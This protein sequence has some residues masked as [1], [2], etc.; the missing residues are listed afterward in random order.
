MKDLIN[1]EFKIV[2]IL[3]KGYKVD[4]LT[5]TLIEQFKD[6]NLLLLQDKNLYHS[7]KRLQ[8]CFGMDLIEQINYYADEFDVLIIDKIK[9]YVNSQDTIKFIEAISQMDKLNGKQFIFI[10]TSNTNSYSVN[11]ND[12]IN[13]KDTILKYS[14][15]VYVLQRTE[16][17][18][19]TDGKYKFENI[20]TQE[21]RFLK[22]K[23]NSVRIMLEDVV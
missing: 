8:L 19:I 3:G 22:E 12:F 10:F 14:N 13:L 23:A 16:P 6:K 21:I 20:L 4:Y 15:E 2:S 17:E 5:A 9:D 7:C 11:I 1:N 18:Y